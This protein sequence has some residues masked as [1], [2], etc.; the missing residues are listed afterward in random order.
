MIPM[1]AI[2]TRVV[3]LTMV[4]IMMMISSVHPNLAVD[5]NGEDDMPK[6]VLIMLLL[7]AAAAEEHDRKQQQQRDG[8]PRQ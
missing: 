8:R 7:M 2:H 4:E 3:I 6:R 5:V 1:I